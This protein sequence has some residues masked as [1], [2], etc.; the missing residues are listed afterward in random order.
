MRQSSR[1]VQAM[2]NGAAGDRN[3]SL[4]IVA[5]PLSSSPLTRERPLAHNQEFAFRR[6]W[7]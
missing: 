5:K 2:K 4:R 1:L 3:A 6:S 7:L